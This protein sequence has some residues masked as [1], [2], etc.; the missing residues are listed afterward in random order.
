MRVKSCHRL[1]APPAD[2]GFSGE[3]GARGLQMEDAVNVLPRGSFHSI[4]APALLFCLI[5][6][7][8]RSLPPSS[9]LAGCDADGTLVD[10]ATRTGG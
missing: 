2:G 9:R 8:S 10:S 1:N 5:T 4:S 6:N 7:L 3:D